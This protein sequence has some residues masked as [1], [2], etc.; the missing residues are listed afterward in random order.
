MNYGCENKA[1]ISI[2]IIKNEQVLQLTQLTPCSSY[3]ELII[4]ENSFSSIHPKI[5]IS[6]D[7]SERRKKA[8]MKNVYVYCIL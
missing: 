2:I 1:H 4:S 7:L 5:I 6:K 8:F 3:I